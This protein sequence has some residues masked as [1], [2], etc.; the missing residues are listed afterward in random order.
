MLSVDPVNDFTAVTLPRILAKN[1]LRGRD[2]LAI[3]DFTGEELQLILAAAMR[4]KG[5]RKN[6]PTRQDEYRHALDGGHIAMLFQKPSLRT[7]TTFQIAIEELGGSAVYLSP[8]EVGLGERESVPDVARNLERWVNA[9]VARVNRHEDLQTLAYYA[10][11]PVINALSDVEHPAQALAD[12]LTIYEKKGSL[13]GQRIAYVGDGNNV[14]LSLMLAAGKLGV[15]MSVAM[16]LG[17]RP[18]PETEKKV[19]ELFRSGQTPLLVTDDPK[20]AVAGA[21]VVYTDTWISMGQ[22]E[23]SEK[24]REAFAHYQVNRELMGLAAPDAIFMH[25]LPAHR[26]EE[27]T[28]EVMDSPQSAIF[29]QSENRLHVHKAIL[30]LTLHVAGP[31]AP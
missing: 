16:P 17:Y 9:I 24:R 21:T 30:L 18:K 19:D 2:F 10:S 6:T 4:L 3:D 15:P 23:E 8:Q 25:C 31:I 28:D 5:R 20:R 14:A 29:D 26:G 11:A 7:R 27:V 13:N 1:P 22:E 12:L